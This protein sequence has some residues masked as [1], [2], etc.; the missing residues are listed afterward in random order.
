[1][2]IPRRVWFS[3]EWLCVCPW[4]GCHPDRLLS[5]ASECDIGLKDHTVDSSRGQNTQNPLVKTSLNS[6]P[7]L[8]F[9]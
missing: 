2:L 7:A 9:P 1:M 5:L 8:A 4:H 6:L 3:V